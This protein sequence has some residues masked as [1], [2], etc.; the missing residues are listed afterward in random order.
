MPAKFRSITSSIM[1]Q[2]LRSGFFESCGLKG[3]LWIGT[4]GMTDLLELCEFRRLVD[5][6]Y[7]FSHHT[8]PV[9]FLCC[10]RTH[11]PAFR[12]TAVKK[13]CCLEKV[14]FVQSNVWVGLVGQQHQQERLDPVWSILFTLTVLTFYWMG[15]SGWHHVWHY[16]RPV[17]KQSKQS[18]VIKK[19]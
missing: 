1:D 3:C 11:F 12:A 10:D 5:L 7:H 16:L 17:P 6:L 19:W 8:I 2:G 15:Y 4:S 9:L 18:F 13:C 14:H